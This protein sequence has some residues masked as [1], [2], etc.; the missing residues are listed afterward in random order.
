[1][2]Y[3]FAVS[4]YRGGD[5]VDIG[6]G[7]GRLCWRYRICPPER[8]IGVDPAGDL[9][10]TLMETMRGRARGLIGTAEA[11]TLPDRCVDLIVCSECFEHLADPGLAMREFVRILRPG[12]EILIQSPSAYQLRNLNPLHL[13][14]T[15]IGRLAP[16]MLQRTVVHEATFLK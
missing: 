11:T 13:V 7:D 10:K 3:A 4:R 15:W 16:R 6:C 14:T 8:Y 12:G 1:L 5:V 9:I 2:R